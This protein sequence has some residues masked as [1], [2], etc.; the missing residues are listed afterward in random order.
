MS[1]ASCAPP[2]PTDIS[3]PEEFLA[4]KVVK[5]KPIPSWK[6][7]LAQS[8]ASPVVLSDH[9][10]FDWKS[11][12][13][14]SSTCGIDALPLEVFEMIVNHLKL[15]DLKS[16]RLVNK[17]HLLRLTP[18]VFRHITVHLH[19]TSF[20]GLHSIAAHSHLR[21]LVRSLTYDIRMV[22]EFKK[23]GAWQSIKERYV[24]PEYNTE[25]ATF[26]DYEEY[27]AAQVLAAK[28]DRQ[29]LEQ[30]F[31]KLPCLTS[32]ELS[33]GPTVIG[34]DWIYPKFTEFD[35]EKFGSLIPILGTV[36]CALGSRKHQDRF[37]SLLLA[38]TALGDR[39]TSLTLDK[40]D[41]TAERLL[42]ILSR[43]LDKQQPLQHLK[44]LKL[45]LNVL[46][47]RKIYQN[48]YMYSTGR[49]PYCMSSVGELDSLELRFHYT[50][51][52]SVWGPFEDAVVPYSELGR[53]HIWQ[54]YIEVYLSTGPTVKKLALTNVA[55]T[56]TQL[57]AALEGTKGLQHLR[58]E[59]IRLT[60]GSWVE[61]FE[62][63]ATVWTVSI[64][65]I[66]LRGEFSSSM[67]CW[68]ADAT[69][70]ISKSSV[71]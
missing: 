11:F 14:R 36:P 15:C 27:Y 51:R 26:A 61:V 37:L 71:F 62:D 6:W 33:T 35:I 49:M 41:W 19:P 10:E 38:S 65:S 69:S 60:E 59:N 44:H 1:I 9:E 28:A 32:L 46:V 52:Q 4:P 20:Q 63:I 54:T 12:S 18:Q 56:P 48:Y 70:Q 57:Q 39:F 47:G 40:L 16:L 21:H 30:A 22:T 45:G 24:D 55:T 3:S 67:E 42:V 7:S 66:N 2:P 13:C 53:D 50:E 8:S 68:Q 31:K 5:P 23:E 64:V 43:K 34:A 29:N 25:G 58:L 17:A